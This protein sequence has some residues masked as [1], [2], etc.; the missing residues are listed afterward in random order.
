MTLVRLITFK[1]AILE[2][3]VK[4]SSCTP[5]VKKAFA[6]SSLRFSNGRTAMRFFRSAW[7]LARPVAQD[8]LIGQQQN[9]GH[10]QHRHDPAIDASA[11]LACFW[12]QRTS[13]LLALQTLR[14]PLIKPGEENPKRE[15]DR[16][17]H[18][19]PAHQPIGN[20]EEGK[21]LR[22]HLHQKPRARGIKRCRPEDIAPLQ[23][24]EEVALIQPD[25]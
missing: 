19:D 20:L 23:L 15:A 2:R 1:S 25:Y 3:S 22:R 24:G 10:G 6:F 12:L 8:E 13:L 16:R 18:D 9:H 21:D 17:R 14:C 11:R 7:D 4:I 5:S